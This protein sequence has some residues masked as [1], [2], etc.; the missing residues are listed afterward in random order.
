MIRLRRRIVD[1]A[2]HQILTNWLKRATSGTPIFIIEA[3]AT[4]VRAFLEAAVWSLASIALILFVA[5]RRLRD[6][7][8]T[9]VPL[10]VAVVV[11]LETCVAIGLER[12]EPGPN[13][14]FQLLAIEFRQHHRAAP[15]LGR[16]GRLQNLL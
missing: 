2:N 10:M 16:G 1:K 9:L 3:A 13:Q 11:T 4:I 6:V 14:D 12:K 5:L 7:V 15:A 8:L